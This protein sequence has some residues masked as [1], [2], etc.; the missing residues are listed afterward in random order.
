ML[1]LDIEG[2]IIDDLTER[3]WVDETHLDKIRDFVNVDGKFTI[4]T[5]G[6][7]NHSEIDNDLIKLIAEKLGGEC[8]GVL[9]KADVLRVISGKNT[10]EFTWYEEIRLTESH[11]ITKES[12]L[13][14]IRHNLDKTEVILID[15]TVESVEMYFIDN[16]QQLT[17]MNVKDI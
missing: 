16:C 5:F 6:W 15:D 8:V 14:A 9:T 13:R 12:G 3:N 10:E 17:L 1:L 2:T 11:N 7:L 4:F